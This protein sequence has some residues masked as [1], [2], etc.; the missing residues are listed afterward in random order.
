MQS[1]KQ[2]SKQSQLIDHVFS[3]NIM[4]NAL[5]ALENLAEFYGY[6]G[7]KIFDYYS[8]NAR[9][10]ESSLTDAVILQL[11]LFRN[12][13]LNYVSNYSIYNFPI[14]L[15]REN[16]ICYLLE[17]KQYAP[18]QSQAYYS[19]MISYLSG[20]S[21]VSGIEKKI[22]ERMK[23]WGPTKKEDLLRVSRASAYT[24]SYMFNQ[25]DIV[26]NSYNKTG[27][28]PVNARLGEPKGNNSLQN[29]LFQCEKTLPKQNEKLISEDENIRKGFINI[30]NKCM[31]GKKILESD[32]EDLEKNI[33][34]LDIIKSSMKI[35]EKDILSKLKFYED[36]V[37][38][39]QELGD[40][41]LIKLVKA[42]CNKI[43]T[44]YRAI[45]ERESLK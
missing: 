39:F 9:F 28:Y 7:K 10:D 31:K 33:E 44:I 36:I 1:Q 43:M 41:K 24:N 20:N 8:G 17:L 21:N 11:G 35:E 26:K 6:K 4:L 23:E 18:P 19:E 12:S 30:Y 2:I 25:I 42:F 40:E 32:F 22:K 34:Y 13:H 38:K 3:N 5:S 45:L 14:N 29:E 27:D 16:I 15:T 37:K